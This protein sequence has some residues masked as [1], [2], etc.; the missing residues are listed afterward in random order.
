MKRQKVYLLVACLLALLAVLT[1][2][3]KKVGLN[4]T[5][6]VLTGTGYY[7]D[8]ETAPSGLYPIGGNFN[9]TLCKSLLNQYLRLT[10][11]GQKDWYKGYFNQQIFLSSKTIIEENLD[12]TTVQNIAAEF[13]AKFEGIQQ[14]VTDHSLRTGQWNEGS[15][16]LHYGTY[17]K[18][19]GDLII[20]LQPGW[21]VDDN[22]T[23]QK[24]IVK[25]NNAVVTPLIF[26][27][28]GLKPAKIE[29]SVYATEIA[30]TIAKFLRIPSPNACSDL[31]LPEVK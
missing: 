19:R 5:L 29:R 16:S 30:P 8:T 17:H 26:M 18:G 1:I 12:L 24:G 27:G 6:V 9:L 13:V 23:G 22:L 14:V 21:G 7:T 15:A 11:G 3:H 10:F 20:E 31:P 28:N 4:K 25:R 2:V